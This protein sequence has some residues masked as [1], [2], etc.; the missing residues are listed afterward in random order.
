MIL[1][2]ILIFILLIY[3]FWIYIKLA[4][5]GKGFFF[6]D[7]KRMSSEMSKKL[8]GFFINYDTLYGKFSF[9]F[10]FTLCVLELVLLFYIIY[11]LA[12]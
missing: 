5:C 6:P 10:V 9:Y 2:F 12:K 7:F 3:P 1:T 4:I 11:S 8:N